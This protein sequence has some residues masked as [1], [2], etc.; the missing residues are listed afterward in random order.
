MSAVGN[1][2]AASAHLVQFY[3]ADVQLLVRNV[4]SFMG[5]SLRDGGTSLVVALPERCKAV[6]RQL[7]LENVDVESAIGEGRLVFEDGERLLDQLLVGG[8]PDADRFDATVGNLVRQ[9]DGGAPGRLTVYGEMVGILWSGG[10][11]P[12][13][14]RLE[15]L[16]N[17]LQE[18]VSFTLFCGYCIDV[19]DGHFRPGIVDALLTAHSHFL[20]AGENGHIEAAVR[21]AAFDIS[22]VDAIALRSVPTQIGSTPLPQG[23]AIIMWLRQH[24]SDR[25]DEI[26]A[27]ARDYYRASG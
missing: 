12:A 6:R 27:L 13:A 4:A 15:Q 25:A 24:F 17:A 5:A 1:P 10:N 3:E 19:F 14:V 8:Y 18:R 23:E 26:L 9:M 22:G 21:R 16:W 7:A 11:Y 2:G 20:P